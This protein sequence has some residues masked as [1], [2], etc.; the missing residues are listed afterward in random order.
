MDKGENFNPETVGAAIPTPEKVKL[1]PTYT[2]GHVREALVAGR[3]AS[4]KGWDGKNMFVFRQV[5]STVPQEFVPKMSSLP[6]AVKKEF[7]R[8]EADTEC[9]CGG[10]LKY[11]NQLA[12]VDMKNN[13]QSWSPSTADALAD[14][15]LIFE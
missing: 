1:Q 2:F 3:M 12:I 8:R 4:R 9:D 10:S 6:A 5:P 15:W 14:D 13:I 11:S 7:A